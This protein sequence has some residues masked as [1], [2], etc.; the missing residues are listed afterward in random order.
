[1][2]LGPDGK[3]ARDGDEYKVNQVRHP[4]VARRF[5]KFDKKRKFLKKGHWG[6]QGLP[7]GDGE[8]KEDAYG[9][10]GKKS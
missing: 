3:F 7:V 5:N 6:V 10:V 9:Y 2:V 1:M 8:L 4:R